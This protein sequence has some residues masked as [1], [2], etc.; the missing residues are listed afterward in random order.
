MHFNSNQETY[1]EPI[2][3]HY[4]KGKI[5]SMSSIPF[6]YLTTTSNFDAEL[7]VNSKIMF[8]I[9]YKLGKK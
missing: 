2:L 8:P 9:G 4:L 6:N 3:Y 5:S 1:Y 7:D